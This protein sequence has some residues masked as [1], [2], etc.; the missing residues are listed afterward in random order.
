MEEEDD[1]GIK[2]IDLI[3]IIIEGINMVI[4]VIE[5]DSDLEEEDIKY[6]FN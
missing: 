4:E 6:L 2:E 1:S 3:I 5:E